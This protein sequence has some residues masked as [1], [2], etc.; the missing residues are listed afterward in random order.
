MEARIRELAAQRPQ[1]LRHSPPRDGLPGHDPIVSTRD[2]PLDD[3]LELA[4][5]QNRFSAGICVAHKP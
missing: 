2:L 4:T 1:H 5:A 3:F